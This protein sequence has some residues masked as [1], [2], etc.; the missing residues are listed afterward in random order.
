MYQIGWFST[1]RDKA[2]RD[3]L[4]VVHDNIIQGNIPA[5]ISFVFS[6]QDPDEST[7]AGLFANLVKSYN[8]PLVH[9][10]SQKHRSNHSSP[11]WR[12]SYDFQVMNSLATFSPNICILAGYMLI[13]G[14]DMCREYD[15]I[16]LH[17]A[18]PGGPFGT[19][20]EVIRKLIE[21]NASQSGVMMHLVTPQLDEG[22]PVTYCTYLIKGELFDRY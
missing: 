3:L 2:A 12:D 17:P 22:P 11:Q 16:N 9:L 13:V 1:G 4:T 14:E 20:Q 21:C 10:S 6:N 18:A 19:W 15:M 8:I 7:E 5:A